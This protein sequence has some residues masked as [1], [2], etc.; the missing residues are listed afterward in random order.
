MSLLIDS[1]ELLTSI[2]IDQQRFPCAFPLVMALPLYSS[3]VAAG[4]PS[5]A[6]DYMEGKLDL[7]HFLI[8]HPAATFFV[9]VSGPAMIGTFIQPNDILIVDRSLEA[10][11]GK[12][13]VAIVEGQFLVRR[14]K[15][16]GPKLYLVTENERLPPI[17]VEDS[18]IMIW[19]IVT[20]VIHQV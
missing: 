5:P 15:K 20:T 4:F 9:R 14:L 18:E 1:S 3:T 12:I 2:D 7:N 13:V 17:V 6:D 10:K 19:G 8:Q 11:A 16:F